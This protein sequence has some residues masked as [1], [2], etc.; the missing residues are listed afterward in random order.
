M[1]LE[2]LNKQCEEAGVQNRRISLQAVFTKCDVPKSDAANAIKAMQREVFELAP[3]CLPGIVTAVSTGARFG[4]DQ[5]R[6]SIIDACG[7]GRVAEKI[8]RT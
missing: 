5:V 6:E 7:L 8:Q 1:M 4:I 2:T 3:L